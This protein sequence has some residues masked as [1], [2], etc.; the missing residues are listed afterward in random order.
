MQSFRPTPATEEIAN[1]ITHGLGFLASVAGAVLL[2]HAA[3]LVGNALHVA[4]AAIY[5]A[6]LM[7]LYAASTLYH[8]ARRPQ[9]KRILQVVDHCAIYL[10]IAGTYTPLLLVSL[11]GGWGWTLL[12][13]VWLLALAGIVFKLFFI[14]RWPRL[15]TVLYVLMG[16]MIVVV[17]RPMAGSLPWGALAWIVAGGL[18]YTSGT[19]VFHSKRLPYAHAIWHL[20]VITGSVCHYFAIA[21]YVIIPAS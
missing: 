20:F 7:M 4:S 10:L 16:W 12:G 14:G 15:S 9:A 18:A 21:R 5:G 13:V 6:T 8:A 11:R 3:L 1:S 17:I 2:V 19:L